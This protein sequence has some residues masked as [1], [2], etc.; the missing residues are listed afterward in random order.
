MVSADWGSDPSQVE[1]PSEC[2]CFRSSRRALW[3]CMQAAG[4]RPSPEDTVQRQWKEARGWNQQLLLSSCWLGSE[5]KGKWEAVLL[6][7]WPARVICR[8][9]IGRWL[10]KRTWNLCCPNPSITKQSA[11]EWVWSCEAS[12]QLHRGGYDT[13]T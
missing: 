5:R 13:P 9:P 6:L 8:T 10:T 1:A 11:E 4:A 3:S 12:S 7:P 2:W